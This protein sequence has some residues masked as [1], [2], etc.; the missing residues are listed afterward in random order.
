MIKI[1]A[2]STAY[3]PKEYAEKNNVTIIPLRYLYKD[4]EFVEGWP[5]EFDEFFEDFTK[6][7]LLNMTKQLIMAMKL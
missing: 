3:I 7:K 2:D 5:G 6:T 1:M 4:E